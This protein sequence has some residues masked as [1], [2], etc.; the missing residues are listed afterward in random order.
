MHSEAK[1]SLE[2]QLRDQA[3]E[4]D[5]QFREKE[6]ALLNSIEVANRQLKGLIESRDGFESRMRSS[7]EQSLL[8]SELVARVR[9]KVH[10]SEEVKALAGLRVS[11]L[12]NNIL[13]IKNLHQQNLAE[14]QKVNGEKD[15][16]RRLVDELEEQLSTTFDQQRATSSRF[17]MLQDQALQDANAV[18]RKLE[19]EIEILRAR[20]VPEVL[21]F[22]M[23]KPLD[24][25]K[26]NSI[27][28]PRLPS[29]MTS[30]NVPTHLHLTSAPPPLPLSLPPLLQFR[31]HPFHTTFK[32]RTLLLP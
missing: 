18:K 28:T 2:T 31:F 9:D 32:I 30:M 12:E 29:W 16:A 1:R 7:N 23:F 26:T 14:L 8:L 27:H 19:E 22:F 17:S 20:A 15:K 3:D 4:M 11:E 13:D 10:R 21:S 5:R 6:E 24:A 25:N